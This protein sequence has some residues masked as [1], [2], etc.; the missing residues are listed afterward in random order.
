MEYKHTQIGYLIIAIAAIMIA[1]FLSIAITTKLYSLFIT[2]TII[3]IVILGSFS[4]LTVAIDVESDTLIVK[5]G[6]G[7]YKK[8]FPLKEIVSAN[9]V[10]NKWYYGWGIRLWFWPNMIIYNI[11]GFNAVEIKTKDNKIYRIGTDEPRKLER[12][13]RSAMG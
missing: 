7:I 12:T 2:I 9:E 3:L 5:F 10:K 11:S 4:T 6:Y 13:I 8:T 1:L